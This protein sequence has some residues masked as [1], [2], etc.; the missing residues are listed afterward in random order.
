MKDHPTVSILTTCFNR[1][2]YLADCIQSVLNSHYQDFELIIVD[3]QSS[4]DSLIIAKRFAEQDAR[5]KVHLN[6]KNLGD[7]P[8]R[9]QA[10]S[11][12]SGR[13][14]KYLD[15]DD[16]LGKWALD[17]MV[18]AIQQFPEAGFALFDHGPNRPLFPQLLS[19]EQTYEA[20]YSG[21]HD[22]FHRSPLTAIIRRDAFESLGGFSGTRYVGDFE[23]WH[24]LAEHF[25]MVMMSA[26]PVFWRRHDAQESENNRSNPA[27]PLSY[28]Q[29]SESMLK[30]D[31]CPLNPTKKDHYIQQAKRK[32]ARSIIYGF[33]R[34]GIADGF[35]MKAHA[36]RS[37]LQIFKDAF[38]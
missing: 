16:M 24:R 6:E 4:D 15:A 20:F 19:S 5:I 21:R 35:K 30:R 17:I 2:A 18:D 32:T 26:W 33:R 29:L 12:A 25:P 8:N 3:D 27:I 38:S 34:Y 28:M 10:A 11:L 22:F 37:W 14:I 36:Q 23:M 7:Y 9:N 1:E 13:Y 31:E